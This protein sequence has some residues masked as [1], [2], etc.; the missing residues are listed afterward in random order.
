[1]TRS[2][3]RPVAYCPPRCL[4]LSGNAIVRPGAA[5]IL[6]PHVAEKLPDSKK[7]EAESPPGLGFLSL[8]SVYLTNHFAEDFNLSISF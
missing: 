8:R 5:T 6:R 2:A 1:M 7:A 4:A 3:H